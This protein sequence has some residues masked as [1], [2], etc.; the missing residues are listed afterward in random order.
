VSEVLKISRARLLFVLGG[1]AALTPLSVDL[2]LPAIPSMSA[3]LHATAAEGQMTV[4]AYMLGMCAGQLLYGRASDKYG[5][6]PVLFAGLIV[7][8]LS[9]LGS[10]LATNIE[11]IVVLRLLQALGGCST[12]VTSRATVFDV[13][14]K[15]E[16]A[17]FLSTM[18]LIFGLAPLLGPVIGGWLTVGFGW[19]STFWFLTLAGLAIAAGAYA[20]MPETKPRNTVQAQSS[21]T[22]VQAYGAV[23]SNWPLMRSSLV[24]ALGTAII[25]SFIATSPQLLMNVLHIP[26]EQFGFI[27]GINAVALIVSSQINRFLLSHFPPEALVG[28][29]VVVVFCAGFALWLGAPYAQTLGIWTIIAPM[30]VIMGTLTIVN[31]NS[32]AIAQ[33]HDRGRAGSV[34]AITGSM[35]F[36]SGSI[37][38]AISGF[39]FDGTAGPLAVL[40]MTFMLIAGLLHIS[41]LASNSR[42][43]S[44]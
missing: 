19:R 12:A 37:A 10:A 11:T 2:Y 26:P 40:V 31:T 6:R 4:A 39:V 22:L 30:C 29:A 34:A 25:L 32:T 36:G 27:F 42:A 5:R 1:M 17:K 41:S 23:L 38:A 7:Y 28:G 3:A 20:F 44:H 9:S 21:E 13:F 33:G 24:T 18:V 35:A 14:D 15:H 16:G 43:P 8:I